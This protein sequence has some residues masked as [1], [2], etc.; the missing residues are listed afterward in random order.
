MESKR[1]TKRR[2][3]MEIKRQGERM[4][5]GI[6]TVLSGHLQLATDPKSTQSLN[7]Y[8]YHTN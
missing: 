1:D 5:E 2:E 8:T 6:D 4:K 3:E 7:I